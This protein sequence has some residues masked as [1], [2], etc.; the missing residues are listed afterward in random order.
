MR[1]G[2]KYCTVTRKMEKMLVIV[3]VTMLHRKFRLIV[4]LRAV[5][6]SPNVD[7][8]KTKFIE[9]GESESK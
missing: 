5:L 1:D 3:A 7:Y 6:V 8:S 2:K 4:D 9:S